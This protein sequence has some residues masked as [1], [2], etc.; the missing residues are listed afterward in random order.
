MSIFQV[1]HFDMHSVYRNEL[2]EDKTHQH[3]TIEIY[4]S[5][6]LYYLHLRRFERHL[7]NPPVVKY[8][9]RFNSSLLMKLNTKMLD[10]FTERMEGTE[11]GG[12]LIH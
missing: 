7:L 5:L 12:I 10:Q 6:N 1:V 2:S 11:F 8:N 3:T 9:N 4:D